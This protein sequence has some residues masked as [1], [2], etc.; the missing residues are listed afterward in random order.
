MY[1]EEYVTRMQLGEDRPNTPHVDLR[2]VRHA[3]HNLRR[4]DTVT[5]SYETG[6]RYTVQYVGQAKDRDR[7]R[8]RKSWTRN[9]FV[10]V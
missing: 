5:Q 2:V 3:E 4:P 1:L 10:Y 7:A 6:E 9:S 8:T